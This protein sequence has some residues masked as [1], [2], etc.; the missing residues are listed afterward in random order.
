[1]TVSG[2][3][4]I[5][6]LDPH[7]INFVWES[8]LWPLLWDGLVRYTPDGG[9]QLQPDLA[10]SWES[11]PDLMTWTFHLR[12]GATFANGKEVTADDVVASVARAKDPETGFYRATDLADISDILAVDSST[13]Q[14]TLSRPLA[15]FPWILVKVMIIDPDSIDQMNESPNGSGPYVVTDFEPDQYVTLV[16]NEQYWG[17]PA[18]LDELKVVRSEESPAVTSLRAGDL[19]AVWNV[20]WPTVTELNDSADIDIIIADTPNT[21]NV[22]DV[23]YLSPPFND[24]RARQALAYSVNRQA[25]V[26]TIYGGYGTVNPTNQPIPP[27]SDL[28][29]T[30]LP[31][32]TFNLDK[33]KSLFAEAGINEGDS[34][35]YWTPAGAYDHW[36]AQGEILQADF[37]KMGID[38]QI[39]SAEINTWSARV[40]GGASYPG[41]IFPNI[42][43]GPSPQILYSFK[44]GA[45]ENNYANPDYD[46]VV[47]EADGAQ[48]E[49][50]RTSLYHMAEEIFAEDAPTTI[51]VQTSLPIAVR[52]DIVNVWIDPIGFPHFETAFRQ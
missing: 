51:I 38:L 11:T 30:S 25:I 6:Q 2:S 7:K 20:P 17:E 18:P 39:E 33:A 27:Q 42:Y 50:E 21:N 48:D 45:A 37:A 34:L 12:S 14:F 52:F 10:L 28:F 41:V 49:A 44:T 8:V 16:P 36:T 1:M 23:D 15:T 43:A 22:I 3:S 40:S 47:D 13:V 9:E 46:A 31:D 26:D 4:S 19:D 29:E 32:Y 24:R 5:T 35:T